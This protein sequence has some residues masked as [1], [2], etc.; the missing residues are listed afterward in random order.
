MQ[1]KGVDGIGG[2]PAGSPPLA[3]CAVTRDQLHRQGAMGQ[4][5]MH[6]GRG[7]SAAAIK[8]TLSAAI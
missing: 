2:I 5:G 8:E 4:C 1:T 7:T 6:D 3:S